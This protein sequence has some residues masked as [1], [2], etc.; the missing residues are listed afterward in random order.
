MSGSTDRCHAGIITGV[1]HG[2]PRRC[3]GP[4][5][6]VP[7][8]KLHFGPSGGEVDGL[9][10][11][12]RYGHI[13]GCTGGGREVTVSRLADSNRHR[14]C[15]LGVELAGGRIHSDNEQLLLVV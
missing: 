8:T 12:F 2:K 3:G 1:G 11:V 13:Q 7:V 14:T 10:T 5:V 6:I 9:G 4:K 15:S